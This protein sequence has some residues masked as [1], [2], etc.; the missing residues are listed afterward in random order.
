MRE[1]LYR[2]VYWIADI[3]TRLLT[4]NDKYEYEFTDKQL[5]FIVIGILGML[6]IFVFYPF[7]K[8]LAKND[9]VMV[10]AWIYVITVLTVITF[11]IEIGQRVTNTGI[12]DFSDI[13]FGMGGFL[14]MFF[15]FA[16]IRG[17]Y[18]GIKKLIRLM[19]KH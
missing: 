2:I 15:V 3:H 11:A 5:H 10:I 1:W 13:V 7:F 6:L 17:I 16:V 19:K 14:A 8:W 9:H 18:H 12:M 4:L